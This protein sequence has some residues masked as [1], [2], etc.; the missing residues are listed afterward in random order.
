LSDFD[1]TKWLLLLNK[2]ACADVSVWHEADMASAPAD[3][4][5]QG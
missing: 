5:F 2:A 3:V 1:Y 4:C